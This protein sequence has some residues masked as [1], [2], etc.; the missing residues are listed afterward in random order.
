MCECVGNT[1]YGYHNYYD[2]ATINVK[3]GVPACGPCGPG[4]VYTANADICEYCIEDNYEKIC[5]LCPEGSL[6]SK[7]DV[8]DCCKPCEN[9]RISTNDRTQCVC[10]KD[11]YFDTQCMPCPATQVSNPDQTA[12]ECPQNSFLIGDTC[13]PCVDGGIVIHS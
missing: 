13:I 12:C 4:R 1:F 9:G 8:L 2:P 3:E 6:K 5:P 7:C 10:P 11:H